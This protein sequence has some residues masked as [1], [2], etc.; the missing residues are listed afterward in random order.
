MSIKFQN[1]SFK[2]SSD[3]NDLG[4]VA[5]IDY[6]E[7]SFLFTGDITSDIEKHLVRNYPESLDADVLK[8]AHHGSKHSSCKEFLEIVKPDY[9]YIPVGS[10]LYGH[11]TPEA[12]QRLED[13]GADVYRADIHRDVTFYFDLSGI[14]S[15]KYYNEE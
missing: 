10:N 2:F 1:L 4:I 15:V 12:I 8:V 7:S 11:P 6:G 9:A 5:R 13:V 14:K 3:E